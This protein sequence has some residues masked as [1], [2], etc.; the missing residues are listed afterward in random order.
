MITGKR[1][2]AWLLAAAIVIAITAS[3]HLRADTGTCGGASVTL[4]FTDVSASNVFF[5][6]IAEA[7]FSGLTNGTSPTTYSPSSPVPREQMAAF[8]TRT[9]DQSIHRGSRRAALGQWWTQSGLVNGS[10]IPIGVLPQF[11]A[12]DGEDLWVTNTGSNNLM[13]VHASDANFIGTYTNVPTPEGIIVA[14]GRVLVASYQSPGKLYLI[15]LNDPPG[16][17][18]QLGFNL[19]NNP[20]GIAYDGYRYWTANYGTDAHTG[21]LSR[22]LLGQAVDTYV[23]GFNQPNWI[24][25]DGSSLWVT[26]RGDVAL[27]DVDPATGLVVQS[28]PLAGSVGYPTFDGE[29]VW[30]PCSSPDQIFVVRAVG[31]LRGAVIAQLT[32]NG[33]NVPFQSGFDGERVLITNANSST[34]TLWKATDLSPIAVAGIEFPGKTGCSGVCS[35]GINFWVTCLQGSGI[36]FLARV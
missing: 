28:I 2:R 30:V 31:P 10:L 4:P 12:C 23:A 29:N 26:D 32:G 35:D 7:Y 11:V 17:A 13:R 19:G 33:L 3:N 15:Q 16:P 27:K 36:G 21:S 5:C 22:I 9:L 18:G 24:L 14:N 20:I 25:F 1:K 6:S 8:V 34:V